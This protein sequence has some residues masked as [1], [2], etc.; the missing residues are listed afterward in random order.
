M[1]LQ[2]DIAESVIYDTSCELREKRS[3]DIEFSPWRKGKILCLANVLPVTKV[4]KLAALPEAQTVFVIVTNYQNRTKTHKES[5]TV[6]IVET[7]LKKN[8]IA[9]MPHEMSS[10]NCKSK[11]RL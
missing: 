6:Q 5:E 8:E 11:E 9:P 2:T 10:R 7:N 4:N 3:R 1:K